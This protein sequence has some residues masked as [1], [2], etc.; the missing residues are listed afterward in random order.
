MPEYLSA[1]EAA[2]KLNITPAAVRALIN[3]GELEGAFQNPN[4][5]WVIPASAVTEYKARKAEENK[6]PQKPAAKNKRETTRKEKTDNKKR[7]TKEKKETKTAAKKKKKTSSSGTSTIDD[8]IELLRDRL[9]QSGKSENNSG[10]LLTTLLSQLQGGKKT[11]SL[12]GPDQDVPSLLRELG[13]DQ[14][15]TMNYILKS[16]AVP[17]LDTLAKTLSTPKE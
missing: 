9:S 16:I 2:D 14:P 6:K 17:D 1:A 12:V 8:L 4:R 5:A 13:K 10:N 11:V 7:T 15:E 3:K